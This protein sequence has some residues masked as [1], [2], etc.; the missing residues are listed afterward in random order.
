MRTFPIKK[1]TKNEKRFLFLR[2]SLTQPQLKQHSVTPKPTCKELVLLAATN[3]AGNFGVVTTFWDFWEF[4][5]YELSTN[6][7]KAFNYS[8]VVELLI[9][10]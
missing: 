1:F 3:S 7:P 6:N 9:V 5:Y 2:T 8:Q 10:Y 4:I